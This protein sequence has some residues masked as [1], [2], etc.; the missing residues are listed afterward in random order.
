[1][2]SRRT[3]ATDISAFSRAEVN[4]RDSYDGAPC[5]IIPGCGTPYNLEIAHYISR[6]KSGRGIPMN[7]VTL[8]IKHHRM[9]DTGRAEE[10]NIINRQIKEYL[11]HCYGESWSED[12]LRYQ[13][14]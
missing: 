2:P 8:C 10:S 3:K 7:L 1:M 5:C 11:Q 6:Q 12:N 9:F 13:R 4:D 14:E